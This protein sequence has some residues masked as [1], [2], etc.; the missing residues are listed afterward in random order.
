MDIS[1]FQAFSNDLKRP[2]DAETLAKTGSYNVLLGKCPHFDS[3]R[4]TFD[5]GDKSFKTAFGE[6]F[7]WE[8]VEVLAGPPN[9]SFTWRHW[10]KHVGDWTSTD[11]EVFK[12]TN[13]IVEFEGHCLARVNSD[14]VIESLQLFFDREGFMGQITRKEEPKEKVEVTSS[15]ACSTCSIW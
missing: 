10:G 7:A 6:G 8:V 1:K 15:P 11:G 4:E 3:T 9:V 14:L 2:V 12:P 5:S 13:R